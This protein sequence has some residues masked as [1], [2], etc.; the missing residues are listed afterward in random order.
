M[1]GILSQMKT[2][3]GA[4]IAGFLAAGL[5]AGCDNVVEEAARATADGGEA[6]DG[7]QDKSTSEAKWLTDLH[8]ALEQAKETDRQVLINITGSDWCPPC[9][10]LKENVFEKPKFQDYASENLVL[11]EVDFPRRKELSPEQKEHNQAISDGYRAEAYPT[12]ILA[13]ANARE[14]KRMTGAEART[15]DA[16]IEWLEN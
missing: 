3:Q 9:M 11:L 4:A 2:F 1:N 10:F 12:L 16:F 13:D 15:P 5:L 14:L 6:M 8:F 7:G